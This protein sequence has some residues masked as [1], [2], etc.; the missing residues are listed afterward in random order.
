[1]SATMPYSWIS[2]GHVRSYGSFMVAIFETIHKQ[3]N[4][5]FICAVA[6]NNISSMHNRI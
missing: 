2:R 4:M 3:A 6:A 5:I 1:M